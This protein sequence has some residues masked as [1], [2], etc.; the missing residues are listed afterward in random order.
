MSNISENL[1][2]PSSRLP[3][4][5]LPTLEGGIATPV[6]R[7]GRGSSIILVLHALHCPECASHLAEVF[8]RRGELDEWD[9]RVLVVVREEGSATAT[10]IG[11]GGAFPSLLDSR[12]SLASR[13][14]VETP[15]TIVADQ[16]GVVHERHSA[17][18]KHDFLPVDEL[19][20]WV[21]Y[22]AIQ[23]PECE[24]EAF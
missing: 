23:C 1:K 15:A 19:V 16:W 5:T 7:P 6:R 2:N 20:E 24:G 22:L 12:D 8:G 9:G 18:A 14:G 10:A 11:T 17:G 3:E 21:R 13:L 4:I